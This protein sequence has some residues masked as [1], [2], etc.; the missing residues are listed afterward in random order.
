[1]VERSEQAIARLKA[2]AQ[3]AKMKGELEQ[4]QDKRVHDWKIIEPDEEKGIWWWCRKCGL[5][6]RTHVRL[7]TSEREI[8][9]HLEPANAHETWCG[10]H[11]CERGEPCRPGTG[12]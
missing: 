1:M 5:L 4:L 9:E 8:L 12:R 7:G 10:R 6:Q 2:D 11:G 3:A